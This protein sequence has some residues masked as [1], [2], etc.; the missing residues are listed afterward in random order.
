MKTSKILL[1]FFFLPLCCFSQ[2]IIK[3]GYIID[4]SGSKIAGYHKLYQQYE[5]TNNIFFSTSKNNFK[6]YNPSQIKEY[7]IGDEVI[8]QS[9]TIPLLDEYLLPSSQTEQRFLKKLIIGEISLF[10]LLEGDRKLYY[11]SK[12]EAPL[13][14]L[15][16]QMKGVS[17]KQINPKEYVVKGKTLSFSDYNDRIKYSSN[18]FYILRDSVYFA[19]PT[20]I[21]TIKEMTSEQTKSMNRTLS[22][23]YSK[24]NFAT[25][26]RKYNDLKPDKSSK[27]Y[28]R[29]FFP[30]ISVLGTWERNKSYS[31]VNLS[32]KSL[33]IEFRNNNYSP[34]V[35]AS[36]SLNYSSIKDTIEYYAEP[37]K[38]G[39]SG[40]SSIFEIDLIG[41]QSTFR[42]QTYRLN[43]HLLPGKNLRPYAYFGFKFYKIKG[44]NAYNISRPEA[45][46]IPTVFS[47]AAEQIGVGLDQYFGRV[48][49]RTEVGW[50]GTL[51]FKVGI[52]ALL[53]K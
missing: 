23:D 1:I 20:Y 39:S 43:Y 35:S 45:E 36:I 3:E 10:Q 11:V 44:R 26:I 49:L 2:Q 13:I 4:L 29:P 19:Y 5:R 53:V 41:Q 48:Q 40:G 9:E 51:D 12:N 34:R 32:E 18:R 27:N 46:A 37:V 8:F 22:L 16:Y 24:K 21:N 7:G 31:L 25:Y 15:S 47:G 52:G 14:P 28:K 42:S 6:E 33:T 30:Q 17:A 50:G 38:V